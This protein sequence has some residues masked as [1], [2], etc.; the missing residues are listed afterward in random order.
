VRATEVDVVMAAIVGAAGLPSTIA[1]AAAGKRVLLANKE[2][3][4]VAGSLLID[5]ARHGGAVLIPIDSEH[6][7]IFQC[8]PASHATG[9]LGPGVRR[10]LLTAS[11]GPFLRRPR[12]EMDRVTPDEACAHPRWRMG[13]KIS[14]DSATLMNKGLEL[15]EACVL[16]GTEPR[17][18]EV[19][20]HPQS[21]VHSMVEYVD[22]SVIAQ[23]SNPDMRV[24]IAHA[25]AYPERIE[26]GA[27]HLDLTQHK[28]LSFEQPDH[29][30][31]PCLALA[32]AALRDG[33]SA[34]AV[35]NAANEVAVEAFLGGRLGFT[36]IAR[37]IRETMA[38]VPAGPADGL[39]AVLAADRKA[40]ETASALV[41]AQ[42]A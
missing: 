22:G 18:V 41:M 9:R 28:G 21:I 33:G 8:L 3:L 12:A 35:L 24:P 26:S 11:G 19:V 6:N 20:V 13:R 17:Q 39:P 14:V 10:I 25:L 27:R 16:F 34:P 15:I 23:L 31:F 4:V 30:R 40:R 37:V 5:A 1:A 2:S 42:A 36:G 7:A 29:A 38:E 32:Y